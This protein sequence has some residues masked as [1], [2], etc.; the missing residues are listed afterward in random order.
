MAIGISTAMRLGLLQRFELA[1]VLD[2]VAL[3]QFDLGGHALLQF[4]DG[5]AQVALA[6]AELDRD[7][8]LVALVVD[9]GGTGV[10]RDVGDVAQ[11]HEG[12]GAARAGVADAQVAHTLQVV[13][14]GRKV[15]HRQAVLAFTLQHRG[16]HGTAHGRLDGAVHVAR[17]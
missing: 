4:G 13:P 15:A 17:C 11:R 3:G 10:E 14:V 1:R 9:V 12:V 16:G 8:A 5:A 2:A 7:V 6:H